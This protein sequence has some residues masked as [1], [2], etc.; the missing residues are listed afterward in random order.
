[1]NKR[2]KIAYTAFCVALTSMAFTP[3]AQ[4]YLTS[5]F[6]VLNFKP[7][8]SNKTDYFGIYSS[9]TVAKHGWNAGFYVDYARNPLEIGQPLGN[10]VLG[11]VDDTITG[12]FY[13]TYGILDWFSVGLNIPIVFYNNFVDNVPQPPFGTGSGIRDKQ[14][15]L[16]DS[17][18]EFEFRI[19][20][21]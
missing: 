10:R 15:N 17:R 11:V 16:V 9:Q 12:N 13:A 2:L 14:T 20:N 5:S 6:D 8:I 19:L 3:R 7:A 21:N 18:L 4:A 1:M